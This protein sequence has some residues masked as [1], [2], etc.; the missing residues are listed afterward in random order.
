VLTPLLKR[1]GS[2]LLRILSESKRK[3]R[4]SFLKQKAW[5]MNLSLSSSIPQ[6]KDNGVAAVDL[7]KCWSRRS[8]EGSIL[9]RNIWSARRSHHSMNQCL[10]VLR[11]AQA[12]QTKIF[13]KDMPAIITWDRSLISRKS[14]KGS[15]KPRCFWKSFARPS[16]NAYHPTMFLVKIANRIKPNLRRISQR[17]WLLHLEK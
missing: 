11:G 6:K 2:L 1:Q 5:I 3:W 13:G 12:A 9:T 14:I 8:P 15:P 4:A 7:K 16:T 10:S 17:W